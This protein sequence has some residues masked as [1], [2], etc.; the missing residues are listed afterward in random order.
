MHI[1]I[2]EKK[3]RFKG[4]WPSREEASAFSV[5]HN[6]PNYYSNSYVF[7]SVLLPSGCHISPLFKK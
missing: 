7:A 1:R 3:G 6:A 4:W 2:L 5:G